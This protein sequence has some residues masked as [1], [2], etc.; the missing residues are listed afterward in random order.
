MTNEELEEQLKELDGYKGRATELISVYI[1]E[2]YDVNSVQKQLEGEKS[3][4]KN[5]S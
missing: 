5:D 3:T 2:G 1:S 4:A